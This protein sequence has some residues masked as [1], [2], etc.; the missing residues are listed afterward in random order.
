M[1]L[2]YAFGKQSHFLNKHQGACPDLERAFRAEQ[3]GGFIH[4]YEDGKLIGVVEFSPLIGRI[5]KGS[6]PWMKTPRKIFVLMERYIR[7]VVR[8]RQIRS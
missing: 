3:G 1:K 7:R 5:A 6:K 8:C 4:V 2:T